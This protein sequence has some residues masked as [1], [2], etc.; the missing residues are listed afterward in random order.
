MVDTPRGDQVWVYE[1]RTYPNVGLNAVVGRPRDSWSM[2]PARFDEMRP[3]CY[4]IEARVRDMDLNGVWASLCF[5]SLV[6]GFCGAVFS[7]SN[8]LELG[9]ACVRAWNDWHAK[10]WAG[11]SSRTHH[12]SAVAVAGRRRPGRRGDPAQR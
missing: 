10:V 2:D 3:G 5:P 8:D 11:T 9:L 1:D 12:S 4:D 7:K 6:A